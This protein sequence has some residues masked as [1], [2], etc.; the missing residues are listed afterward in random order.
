LKKKK[1]RSVNLK[2][3]AARKRQRP[4]MTPAARKKPKPPRKS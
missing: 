2:K 3:S 1:N 4:A